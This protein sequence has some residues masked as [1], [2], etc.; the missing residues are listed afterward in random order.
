MLQVIKADIVGDE[1]SE[2][3]VLNAGVSEH[4]DAAGR[5]TGAALRDNDSAI[6]ALHKQ[7]LRNEVKGGCSKEVK[8]SGVQGGNED[9][10][11]GSVGNCACRLT[12][13]R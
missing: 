9:R 7:A 4:A 1:E 8:G 11:V 6:I 5:V 10:E 2:A 12:L 13:L 3:T